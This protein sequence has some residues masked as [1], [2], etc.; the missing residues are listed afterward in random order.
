MAQQAPEQQLLPLDAMS[1]RH[2][3]FTEEVAGSYRQAALVCLDRHHQSPVTFRIQDDEVY[4]QAGVVWVA[5]DARTRAAW[6]NEDDA[7]RDGAYA[8]ALA[9]TELTRGLVALR[10][11]E[12]KTGADYYIAAPGTPLEDL[13]DCLRLE[14][15]GTSKGTLNDIEVRLLE[16]VNQAR[17]GQSNLPALA[18]VV[19]FKALKIAVK[20]LQN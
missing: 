3:G 5:T 11:A 8:C 15:S 10:R 7:T 12:T 13:E 14:V 19:G 18:A 6:A 4:S 17:R 2:T 20:S 9:S 16:K 1:E